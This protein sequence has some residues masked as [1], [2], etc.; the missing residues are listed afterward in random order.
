MP[1]GRKTTNT[2]NPE[3]DT[4]KKTTRRKKAVEVPVEATSAVE[5]AATDAVVNVP[6]EVP[7]VPEAPAPKKRGRKP[8]A[9]ADAVT[10][11]APVKK[12]RG[13]KAKAETTADAPVK[14][15]RGRKKAT[16]EVVAEAAPPV[17]AETAVED[18]S[19]NIQPDVVVDVPESVV[20]EAT[21]ETADE[22]IPGQ[23]SID[24]NSDVPAEEPTPVKMQRKPRGAKTADAPKRRGRPP[25]SKTPEL[26][27]TTTLQIGDT[28]FDISGIAEK[29]YKEYKRVHKRK[30][31]TDF[32]VYVKPDE[33]AAY[34]TINGEG[35][36]D[37]KMDLT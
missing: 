15:A 33:G 5:S 3:N 16:P 26:V 32:H 21:P 27:L 19:V 10:T 8:K 30:I 13:R 24:G 7:E 11:D 12:T 37:F 17:E 9:A 1:R 6:A 14:K 22:P 28:E 2:A 18:A 29:A 4:K 36:E 35:S 31:I 23:H 34:Y 25:K 20:E